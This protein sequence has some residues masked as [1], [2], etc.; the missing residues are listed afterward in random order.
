MGAQG[1][2]TFVRWDANTLNTP[3]KAGLT[4]TTEGFAICVGNYSTY[5]TIIAWCVGSS[6]MYAF[7]V[8]NGDVFTW[9]E[10]ATKNDLPI[11]ETGYYHFEGIAAGQSMMVPIEYTKSYTGNPYVMLV[12]ASGNGFAV[13][14]A[15]ARTST[16]FNLQAYNPTSGAINVDARWF[17]VEL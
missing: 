9:K 16:G 15:G 3:Y 7:C 2:P 13:L 17:T 6:K 1:I 8:S 10:Y 5:Q 14:V 4:Q 12:N 11:K